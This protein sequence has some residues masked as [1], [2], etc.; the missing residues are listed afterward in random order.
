MSAAAGAALAER[1]S[2][3]V[4]AAHERRALIAGAIE[5]GSATVDDTYPP[6][7]PGKPV[8]YE[9]AYYNLSWTATTEREQTV[10]PIEIDYNPTDTTGSAIAFADLPAVDREALSGIIPP[11]RERFDDGPDMGVTV[12][13]TERER[14]ASV[15]VPESEYAF[16]THDG[17]RYRV[18]VQEPR[19]RTVTTYRYSASEV[20]PDAETY[21]AQLREQYLFSLT[22][23]STAERKVVEEAI[24]GGYYAE[25]TGDEAFR[26]LLNRFREE[27]A[28]TRDEFSG[29]WVADYEGTTYWSEV[30]FGQ[31]AEE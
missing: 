5:N 19:T 9:G 21:A 17:N 13:Y 31:F 3:T 18:L 2:R 20:A 6:L 27:R 4:D 22:N 14:E 10:Y 29:E 1:A 16:V 11:R 15:L 7:E 26:S 25:S 24:D 23:L 30:R 12:P 28:V 8:G